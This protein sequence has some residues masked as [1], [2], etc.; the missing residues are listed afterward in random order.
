MHVLKHRAPKPEK[1]VPVVSHWKVP[2]TK[3]MRGKK[4]SATGEYLGPSG[5]PKP[6]PDPYTIAIVKQAYEEAAKLGPVIDGGEFDLNRFRPMPGKVLVV[7]PPM[8]KEEKGIALPE[9]QWK[10]ESYFIVLSVGRG[11]TDYAQGDR[12]VFDKRHKPK[13]VK[14]G[15]G[16]FYLSPAKWIVA[17]VDGSGAPD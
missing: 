16:G 3:K 13:A 17:V 6:I 11:V 4:Y 14:L 1:L 9:M 2:F 7:R 10:H 15:R 12:V 5:P 8:I